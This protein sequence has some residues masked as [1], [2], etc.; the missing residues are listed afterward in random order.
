[1]K[2][3]VNNATHGIDLHTGALHRANLP[4]VRADLDD[5]ETLRL[6]KAFGVPVLLHSKIR[7]GSLREAVSA[8]GM[9]MLLYEAGEA[10]RFDEASIRAGVRGVINVMRALEMLPTARR[11]RPLPEPYASRSSH[12]VRAPRSGILTDMR[13]LGSHINAGDT[14]AFV[15]DPYGEAPATPVAAELGGVVIGR[16]HL[17]LV[18]EGDAMIHIARFKDAVTVAEKV[19]QFQAES[20]PQL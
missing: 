10:L 8:Q 13:P 17:P 2:E 9:P 20:D 7:D 18:N 11:K 4:H 5:E 15:N 1:M 14:I 16:T 12:W 3:I 6:A 19:D